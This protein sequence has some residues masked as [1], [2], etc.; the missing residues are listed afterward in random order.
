MLYKYSR[1]KWGIA[2][3][4][5][6]R[7]KVSPPEEFNDPFEFTPATMNPLDNIEELNEYMLEQGENSSVASLQKVIPWLKTSSQAAKEFGPNMV[8]GDME[9]LSEASKHFGV[10]CLSEPRADIRMWAHYGDNHRGVAV[11]LDLDNEVSGIGGAVCFDKVQYLNSRPPLNPMLAPSEKFHE[12]MVKITMTKSKVWEDEREHR[13]IF[14]LE[15]LQKE[16][17]EQ[18]S[19]R[20]LDYFIHIRPETIREVAMGCLISPRDENEIR[21]MVKAKLPHVKLVKL[22]RHETEFELVV[23]PAVEALR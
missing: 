10:L 1:V 20:R 14:K 13:M 8:R 23:V 19:P 17:R 6:L 11:G 2:I 9:S 16:E 4:R 3:L 5:E 21:A 15:G 7:L 22:K 18:C 12:Q